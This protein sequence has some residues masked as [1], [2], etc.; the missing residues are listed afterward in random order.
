VL[1]VA[2][3]AL[4]LAADRRIGSASGKATSPRKNRV[5]G[6]CRRPSGRRRAKRPQ[7]AETASGCRVCDY[8]T[9]SGR[10]LW[11][12]RD[13]IGE[14]GGINLYGYVLNDPINLWDSLGDSPNGSRGRAFIRAQVKDPA[15]QAALLNDFNKTWNESQPY[16]YL[17]P[18]TLVGT[19][20]ATE[21]AAVVAK[22]V[23]VDGPKMNKDGIT[24]RLCQLRYRNTP[25]LRLDYHKLPG[26]LKDPVLH[27]N[28]G[29]WDGP[30]SIHIPIQWNP[31]SWMTPPY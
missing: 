7:V 25:L 15:K 22:D 10:G 18:A 16:G 12:S 27:L 29:P 26:P 9:V 17:G 14:A 24:G 1:L 23:K 20:A 13:P 31:G 28:I 19:L 6:F 5:W 2:S 11:P 4:P 8:K 21:A 30:N 3:N